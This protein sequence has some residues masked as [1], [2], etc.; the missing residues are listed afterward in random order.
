[1]SNTQKQSIL[2]VDADSDNQANVKAALKDLDLNVI[3]AESTEEVLGLVLLYD[4]ALILFG[5]DPD[6]LSPFETAVAL[7]NNEKT[8]YVPIIFQAKSEYV[9][10]LL[11]QGYAAGGVDFLHKPIKPTVLLAKVKVFL[12]LDARQQ[13][14]A[15]A[16]A[17]IQ[18]QNLKLEERAIRDS[19]TG[20]YNHK[21]LQEQ[22]AREISLA[23]RYCAPLSVFLLDLDFFKD[24]NDSCGHPF[25]D[26]VLKSFA[27]RVQKDLRESDIFGRYGGEEFLIILPNIDSDHANIVAEKIR[28][29]IAETVFSNSR[30]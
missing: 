26:F 16:T 28:K 18:K 22:L 10:A 17:T 19:L 23:R 1:M 8:W 2:L 27:E 25:G 13:Q 11:E 6:N 30:Y 29:Q 5:V 20:L 21:Y 12:E 3:I 7:D 4:F 24:V 9:G 15:F 14:L